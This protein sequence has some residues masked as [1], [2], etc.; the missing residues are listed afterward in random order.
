MSRE[1]FSKRRGAILMSLMLPALKRSLI[2]RQFSST[3]AW[4]LVLLPPLLFPM[5]WLSL[6][7]RPIHDGGLLQMLNQDLTFLK[8]LLLS[9]RRKFFQRRLF[10]A[11][12]KNICKRC[13]T[14][15]RQESAPRTSCFQYPLY[16]AERPTQIKTVASLFTLRQQFSEPTPFFIC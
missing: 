5:S 4:I 16:A 14:Y 10:V 3:A 8:Q 13:S 6:F 15:R 11:D 2:G 7:L 12:D 1:R 9:T